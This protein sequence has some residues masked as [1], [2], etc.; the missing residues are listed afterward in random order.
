MLE[1]LTK[2]VA[3]GPDL[4]VQEIL[5]R[6]VAGVLIG[7]IV[8]AT[9]YGAQAKSLSAAWPFMTTLTLLTVLVGM[10]SLVIGES[11]AR[12][13]SLVGALSIVRFRTVVEDTRDTAFVIFAVTVGMAAGAGLFLVPLMGIPIVGTVAVA[14]GRL[15]QA[16][17]RGDGSCRVRI[18]I[19]VEAAEKID[20]AGTLSLYLKR[21]DAV[22]SSLSRQGSTIDYTYTG[23]LRNDKSLVELVAGLRSLD[24]IIS[25]K[26]N[27]R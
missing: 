20:L 16:K 26:V 27:C 4:S 21:Q 25:V 6:M 2:T 5:I 17:S 9:H 7:L 15:P 14:L 18:R 22:Q 8:G 13:F 10:T 23:R 11:V 19:P 1:W 12:A 3:P 24:G